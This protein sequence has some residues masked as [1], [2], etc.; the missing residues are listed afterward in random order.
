[1]KINLYIK[2]FIT[3]GIISTALSS[4]ALTRQYEPP[5]VDTQGLYRD[6][7]T[8]DT[9]TIANIPWQSYFSDPYLLSLI[10]EGL[11]NNYDVRIA[12]TRISQ[13]EAY[14]RMAQNA[15]FPTVALAGG[16]THTRQSNGERGKD[17][18]GYGNSQFSLGITASWE[19]DIWGSLRRQSRS[20]YA[21]FLNSIAYRD[22]IRTS[23]IAN[24][25]T[26]YYSLVALDA[27]LFITRETVSLLRESTET[28]QIMMEQ[29]L[30]N[31]AAVEQSR[32]LYY[33]TQVTIPNLETQIR[34]TENMLSTLVGRRPGPITRS[35]IRE[36]PLDSIMYHGVPMQMLSLRP[37]VRQAELAF[38]SAF[39]LT[40]AAHASF[41]PSIT[42][43]NGSQIGFSATS[44][45][46]FFKP[47]H[48]FANIIGGLTQPIFARGQLRGNLRVR[49]AQQEEA[50]LTFEQTV[51]NAGRE[52]SDILFG[53]QA[54]LRKN[55]IRR[56]QLEALRTSVYFTQELLKAG[57]ANYTEVLSAQ[58]NYISARLNQVSDR[59]EQLQYNVNLYKALGGGV[60]E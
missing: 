40:A 52:V 6:S 47:E 51:L 13:A 32:A 27:Q 15:Y 34:Q 49:Q 58:Q 21:Q 19:A 43:G 42:L 20:Q 56:K 4:C 35:H 11:L 59:L 39:E 46:S 57:E 17:V 55:D 14:L 3:M 28:M 18:F 10:D 54:S 23:L 45:S 29:G 53:F 44:L 37:D 31:G 30:L 7:V 38:R 25:A 50:L 16:V 22:L 1:M 12:F 60:A 41:Y 5:A 8:S 2:L 33:S 9:T 24:I 48:L 26:T 36:I